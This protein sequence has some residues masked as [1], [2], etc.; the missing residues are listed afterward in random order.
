[1]TSTA[2]ESPAILGT[3]IVAVPASPVYRDIDDRRGSSP[4]DSAFEGGIAGNVTASPSA[5]QL[6]SLISSTADVLLVYDATGVLQWASPSLGTVF[7]WC[8]KEMVGQRFFLS[9]PNHP[10]D[11]A[12]ESPWQ[13]WCMVAAPSWIQRRQTVR[14]DGRP[15][16]VEEAVTIVRDHQGV[17]TAAV[18]SARDITAHMHAM[19]ALTESEAHFRA[20]AERASEVAY[21][22]DL[23]G[24]L[25]WVSDGVHEALEVDSTTVCDRAMDRLIDPADVPL[26]EAALAAA[27]GGNSRHVRVRLRHTDGSR[28]LW[29]ISLHPVT[30]LDHQIVGVAG[31]WRNIDTDTDRQSRL[32]TSERQLYGLAHAAGDL[33]LE[34]DDDGMIGWV[35]SPAQAL[36]GRSADELIGADVTEV[37]QFD[38]EALRDSAKLPHGRSSGTGWAL[39][40]NGS[41]VPVHIVSRVMKESG[42]STVNHRTRVFSAH[43]V[44]MGERRAAALAG[45]VRVTLR[46]SRGRVQWASPSLTTLLG[47]DPSDW[48]GKQMS[49]YVHQE[50]VERVCAVLS[51]AAPDG[52]DAVRFRAAALD[53]EHT[54]VEVT[55]SRMRRSDGRVTQVIAALTA[56]QL[57]DQ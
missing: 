17:V 2:I 45:E 51:E 43:E 38:T 37:L 46:L 12:M 34:V 7:G 44:F 53:G 41:R 32:E 24:V 30:D 40:A 57:Q 31:G 13:Q 19:Q 28:S 39:R 49:D 29:E 20:V 36:L 5:D 35:S 14:G 48:I 10:D 18:V 33:V 15:S 11:V 21:H 22:V 4:G 27:R 3:E 9:H 1:M 16:W 55:T 50:D 25:T 47:W 52:H 26:W 56:V 54:W 6:L 8:P 42:D 23:D